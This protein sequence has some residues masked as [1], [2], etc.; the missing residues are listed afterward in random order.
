MERVNFKT[1]FM[2]GDES[3]MFVKDKDITEIRI[4]VKSRNIVVVCEDAAPEPLEAKPD[5]SW[6]W[7]GNNG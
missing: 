5:Y 6:Q 4:N 1:D 7:R 2:D 3:V